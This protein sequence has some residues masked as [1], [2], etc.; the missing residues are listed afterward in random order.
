MKQKLVEGIRKALPGEVVHGIEEVYRRGRVE[1][2]SARYGNPARTLKVI[3]V[4][5]T[6]GKTTTVNYINE[7]LKEAGY[8]TAMFSTALIEVA[9]DTQLNDLNATVA[10][11]RRMQEF[12]RDAKNAKVDYVVL[13]ITSHALQQHKLATVPIEVAV[14][15]NL[16]QDHLD[17]HKTMEQYAA[18]KCKLFANSPRFVVLNRD[19]D[20][21]EYFDKYP[22]G[23]HKITYGMHDEAEAKIE[24]I[25]AY[26]KGSEATVVIDHQTKLD[27]ATALPGKFNVYNMTA[28]AATTYLLGVKLKDI[29]EGVANLEGVPGRFERVVEG[30]EYDVIVDYAHTP[31]ALEKLLQAAKEVTKNRT[32]LVFGA[33]GDRDKTKRPIMGEIAA[34]LADRIILTDEESYNEDPQEIRDQVRAGIEA[35]GANAK[36]TEIAD[37]RDAIEKALAIA[38]KGDTILITGMGHEQYRIVNGERLPWNDGDVVRELVKK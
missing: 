3:A 35:A 1:L 37:R 31:D 4:T 25:V 34:R 11:T 21:F 2:M 12:F 8:K 24:K 38:T 10:S 13:E 23:A 27:L 5:G 7:I 32:I 20:W 28:A 22:A 18:A 16:T 6:N 19:D 17:Y 26:K 33:T 14:M 29:I 9:G 30:L 15:T 36:L